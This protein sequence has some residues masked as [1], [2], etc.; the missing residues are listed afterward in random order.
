MAR[1]PSA[2]IAS[3]SAPRVGKLG[4]SS[5]FG[6]KPLGA[7]AVN[8]LPLPISFPGGAKAAILLTF[9]VE[10][11]YGNGAGDETVEIANYRRIADRLN[12]LGLKATFN[13]VGEMAEQ[14][15]SDFVRWLHD[16]GSEIASHGYWHEMNRFGDYT[17]HGQYGFEENLDSLRRSREIL[18][19]IT[20][21]PTRGVRIPYAHA[22][23]FTY[24][25]IIEAGFDWC[26]HWGIDDMMDASQGFGPT[27]FQPALGDTTYNLVEIPL[28][29]QTYDWSIWMADENNASF[30][31]RVRRYC[32]SRKISFK[33]TPSGGVDIWM[34]RVEETMR[35]GGVFSLLCHPINLA[36]RD[37]RWGDPLEEFLF[38][39]FERLAALK[40]AGAILVPTCGEMAGFYRQ[41]Q[42]RV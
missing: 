3:A 11:R 10:G 20:G 22:N 12:R 7:R 25:A 9:D 1:D 24:Q 13:I 39:V 42:A 36:V 29:T 18:S 34:S 19:T 21:C 27:L 38:P 40:N 26:S 33:R 14:K 31:E 6:R 17:Y 28:D 8:S 32:E 16:A 15:G 41:R 4:G 37:P 5:F 23:E 35:Q 30:I 2:D